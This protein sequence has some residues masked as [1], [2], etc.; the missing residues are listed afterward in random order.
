MSAQQVKREIEFQQI[1]AM[2]SPKASPRLSPKHSPLSSGNQGYRTSDKR[3]LS[4]AQAD[5]DRLVPNM[6]QLILFLIACGIGSFQTGWALCGN[7]Q[8]AQILIAQ[9]GW[10]KAEAQRYNSMI[11]SS[12]VL[13]LAIGSFSAGRA[14]SI[15]R[16]KAAIYA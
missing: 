5:L 1:T 16:R 11:N 9:F 15:G 12:A 2:L 6:P 7:S 3:R 8:T 4:V 10:D 13:G 14:I